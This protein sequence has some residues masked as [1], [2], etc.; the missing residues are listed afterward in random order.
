MVW[1]SSDLS[2]GWRRPVWLGFLVA[3]SVV[4]SFAFAR[5]APFAAFAAAA[6]YTLPRRDALARSTGV[7]SA[8][9]FVGF[10]FLSYPWTWNCIAW[11]LAL[12]LSAVLPTLGVHWVVGRLGQFSEPFLYTV[13]L[14]AAFVGYEAVLIASS[15]LLGGLSNFTLVNQGKIFAVNAVALVGLVAL[16]RVG[17][18]VGIASTYRLPLPAASRAF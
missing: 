12:G 13:A 1:E 10:A 8:N 18:A 3:A 2:R 15:L 5:A 4:F 9:Q 6:A 17:V 7:W 11:G 14:V 16:H